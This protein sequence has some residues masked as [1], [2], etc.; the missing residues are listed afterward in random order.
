MT[1][2]VTPS[3]STQAVSAGSGVRFR[4]P[5]VR[6]KPSPGETLF[7]SLPDSVASSQHRDIH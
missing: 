6:S 7:G 4:L 2:A 1:Y 3:Q 5:A